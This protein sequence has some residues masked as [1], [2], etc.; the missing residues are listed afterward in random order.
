MWLLIFIPPLALFI[1]ALLATV[2]EVLRLPLR[3]EARHAQR[4]REAAEP[5]VTG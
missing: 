4:P 5:A 3:R 1:A 2:A